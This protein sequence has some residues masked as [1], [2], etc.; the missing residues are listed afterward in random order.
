MLKASNTC[1]LKTGNQLNCLQGTNVKCEQ[2]GSRRNMKFSH[3]KLVARSWGANLQSQL[4]RGGGG[5]LQ[6]QGQLNCSPDSVQGMTRKL[7]KTL[8]Q[9]IKGGGL[10]K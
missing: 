5:S 10:G 3:F 1:L 8:S 4:K 2:L 9:N 7:S 6:V